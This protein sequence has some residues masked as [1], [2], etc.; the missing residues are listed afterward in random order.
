MASNAEARRTERKNEKNT[1]KEDV[2]WV[3]SDKRGRRFVWNIVESM[4][5]LH[6]DVM[7]SAGRTTEYMLGRRAIAVALFD[8]M[9][10]E[11]PEAKMDMFIE[12][13]TS[14]QKDHNV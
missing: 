8:E 9:G 14:K 13:L 12:N 5:G 1:H 10:R 7:A 3:M 2:K 11:C 6:K 4:G